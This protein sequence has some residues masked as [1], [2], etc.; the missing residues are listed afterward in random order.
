M[1]ICTR[2]SKWCENKCKYEVCV[3]AKRRSC[4]QECGP[5]CESGQ[6]RVMCIHERM[7]T[8][9]RTMNMCEHEVCDEGEVGVNICSGQKFNRETQLVEGLRTR[10]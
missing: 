6:D 9:C 1:C 2:V 3:G 7:L 10:V 5:E 8:V 4:L